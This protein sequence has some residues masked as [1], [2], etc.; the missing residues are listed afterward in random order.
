MWEWIRFWI[1][2]LLLMSGCVT[3]FC[4]VAGVYR[5]DNA[6]ARMHSAAICDSLGALL[7][8]S[9]L[10]VAAGVNWGT[11]KLIVAVVFLWCSSPISAHMVSLLCCR[12]EKSFGSITVID[13]P[14]GKEDKNDG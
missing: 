10:C 2:A 11:V 14:D 1:C 7:I 13:L 8:V 3:L 12:T 6:L 5:F 9:G 4:S